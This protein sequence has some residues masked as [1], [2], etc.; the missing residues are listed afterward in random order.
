MKYFK[1]LLSIS[2]T[3]ALIYLLNSKHGIAPPFAKFLDPFN[4]FWQNAENV[5]SFT[6]VSYKLEGLQDEVKVF[7]DERLVP[8]IFAK[9]D[10]AACSRWRK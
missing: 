7:F 2:L 4:G 10:E 6:D 3:V 8:H 9:N 5:K 1:F